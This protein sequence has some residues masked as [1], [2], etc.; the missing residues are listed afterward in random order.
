MCENSV[1]DVC[2]LI[3]EDNHVFPGVSFGAKNAVDGEVG[4]YYQQ[5]S[6][7]CHKQFVFVI[8]ITS[9]TEIEIRIFFVLLF[10]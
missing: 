7:T 9:I 3:L 8:D 2:Y 6:S 10:I 1:G 5:V 4:K